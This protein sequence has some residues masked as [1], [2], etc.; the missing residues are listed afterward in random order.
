[1]NYLGGT[2]E[3][4]FFSTGIALPEDKLF[5]HAPSFKVVFFNPYNRCHAHNRTNQNIV[6]IVGGTRFGWVVVVFALVDLLE[7]ELLA[8]IDRVL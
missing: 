8:K 6:D 1:M 2:D 7:V 3:P 4:L 5:C